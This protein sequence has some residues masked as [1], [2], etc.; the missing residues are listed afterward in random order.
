ML[1]KVRIL[2]PVSVPSV[3][4]WLYERKP[5]TELY[6][7]LMRSFIEIRILICPNNTK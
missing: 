6:G 1:R 4:L 5:V 3:M 7:L 2:I